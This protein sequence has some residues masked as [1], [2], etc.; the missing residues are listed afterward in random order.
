MIQRQSESQKAVALWRE[1]FLG[2]EGRKKTAEANQFLYNTFVRSGNF[3]AFEL[4]FNRQT[5]PVP[6]DESSITALGISHDGM[7]YGGTSS[8]NG[9]SHLFAG[10]LQNLAGGFYNLGPV[11]GFNH[12]DAVLCDND[13]VYYVLSNQSHTQLF[14]LPLLDL[15]GDMIQE[16]SHI[17]PNLESLCTLG[18]GKFQ[19]AASTGKDSALAIIGNRVCCVTLSTGSISAEY[20]FKSSGLPAATPG[21]A[22]IQNRDGE[23]FLFKGNTIQPVTGFRTGPV[24]AS[25][26]DNDG[27]LILADKAGKV[28]AFSKDGEKL[29]ET[30]LDITPITA[31]GRSGGTIYGFTG[32][33]IQQYFHIL[34]GT[35]EA[36]MLGVVVSVIERRRYGYNFSCP[37]VKGS[38]GQLFWGENDNHGHVFMYFP[39][40]E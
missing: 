11:T 15:P 21:G 38:D 2:H 3:A 7:L 4:C 29:L 33:G 27:T 22:I 6:L 24:T 34:P 17:F 23:I 14:K 32:E 36:E 20:P 12:C 26:L 5:K 16:S 13:S 40:V 39:P 8:Q 10:L 9:E 19:G 18:E 31:L 25:F 1:D 28:Y 30:I 37:A 35:V